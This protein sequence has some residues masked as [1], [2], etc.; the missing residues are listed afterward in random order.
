MQVVVVDTNIF[1]SALL[2]ADS[3]PREVVRLCLRREVKPLMG[4]ALLAEYED[5]LSRA[6]LFARCALSV[7]RRDALFDAFLSV[8]SWI[9]VS[10]LWRPNLKDEADNHLIELAVAGNA[11]WVITG[12]VRDVAHGEILFP[13]LKIGNAGAFLAEWRSIWAP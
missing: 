9:R 11:N 1:V 6:S 3:A 2:R 12:N 7:T 4:N 10:Y 13:D 8:C 5:V